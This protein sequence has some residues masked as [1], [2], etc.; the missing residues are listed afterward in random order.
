MCLGV[1]DPSARRVLGRLDPALAEEVDAQRCER[2]RR[3]VRHDREE[4]GQG[5]VDHVEERD[6][7]DGRQGRRGLGADQAGAD[8]DH[9]PP[10]LT[11]PLHQRDE[12]GARGVLVAAGEPRHGRPRIPQP[13]R[14]DEPR[15]L[16]DE[17]LAAAGRRHGQ[18]PRRQ[19]EPRHEAVDMGDPALRQD[20]RRR[21]HRQAPRRE[22]SL[23][24]G[25]AVVGQAGADHRHRRTRARELRGARE[26]GDAVADD[27]DRFGHGALRE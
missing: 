20:I 1:H 27:D 19:I 9:P 17:R 8:H 14:P 6:V 26:A 22:R 4:P 13:R 12:A 5:P 21:E 3:R 7:V 10:R 18:P 24:E 25:R 2:G 15:R 16:D 23:G 11:Q